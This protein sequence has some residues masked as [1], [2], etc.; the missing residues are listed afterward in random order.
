MI[1]AILVIKDKHARVWRRPSGTRQV[2]MIRVLNQLL[3]KGFSAFPLPKE[4]PGKLSL[5]VS[6]PYSDDS[7]PGIL[8]KN[9]VSHYDIVGTVNELE[10]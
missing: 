1:D 3:N 4:K 7:L 5:L 6:I 9:K 8:D 10:G 2:E